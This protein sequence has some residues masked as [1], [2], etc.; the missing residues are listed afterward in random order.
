MIRGLQTPPGIFMYRTIHKLV[1][2]SELRKGGKY[3]PRIGFIQKPLSSLYRVKRAKTLSEQSQS[4]S[5]NKTEQN[6]ERDDDDD[7]S[8]KRRKRGGGDNSRCPS[9]GRRIPNP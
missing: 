2:T 1:E 5:K 7:R 6:G 9:E 3:N 8:I 4:E